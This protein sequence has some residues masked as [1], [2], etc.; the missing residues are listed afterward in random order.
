MS[1]LAD[2]VTRH[3]PLL[4]RSERV[5]ELRTEDA[6]YL[7]LLYVRAGMLVSRSASAAFA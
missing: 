3:L 2:H 4:Q 1:V 5:L 7:R 6:A